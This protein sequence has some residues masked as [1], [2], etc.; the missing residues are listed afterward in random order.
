MIKYTKKRWVGCLFY[1]DEVYALLNK[2]NPKFK[3]LSQHKHFQTK[4]DATSQIVWLLLVK[5]K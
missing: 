4:Y 3:K 1:Q 2:I 5:T